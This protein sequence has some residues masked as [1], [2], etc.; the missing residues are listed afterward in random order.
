MDL[1][2]K[3]GLTYEALESEK[4][5][6]KLVLCPLLALLNLVNLCEAPIFI[7]KQKFVIT[8]S[9]NSVNNIY[10]CLACS[11]H[12]LIVISMLK[13][14]LFFESVN[15]RNYQFGTEKEKKY[16]LLIYQSPLLTFFYISTYQLYHSNIGIIQQL[17]NYFESTIYNFNFI[18]SNSFPLT[19]TLLIVLGCPFSPGSFASFLISSCFSIH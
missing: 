14:I 4:S 10:L 3:N 12:L 7:C 16:F 18:I 2:T 19:E 13:I 11:L 1:C 17:F 6:F 8:F 9:K 15:S 5:E